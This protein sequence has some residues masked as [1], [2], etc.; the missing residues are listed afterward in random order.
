M[1][2]P[3][4]PVVFVLI[5]GL[6]DCAIDLSAYGAGHKPQTPL[7]AASTPAMDAISGAGLSGLMDPVEPGLACGSDTAHMSIFGYDPQRNYRGRGAFEAMGAGLDMA[8]GDVAFKCNFATLDPKTNVVTLR[9]VDR[10]FH[11]WGKGLCDF[12]NSLE[13][14]CGVPGVRVV[15]KHATEHRCG[16]VFKGEN[17]TDSITGTDPLKDGLPLL[18]SVPAGPHEHAA[19]SATCLNNAS[20]AIHKAL[21]GHPINVD[22]VARGLPPA[23]LIL[24]RGPGERI[25]VP[26][27]AEKHGLRA[28]MIAPTCIIAGLGKS[29][30]MDVVAVAGATGDYHTDLMAKADRAIELFASGAY[31]FGFVHVKAV[32]DAGHDRDVAT[33]V[34]LKFIEKADAMVRQLVQ[35]IAAR[36]DHA[37]IVVTGDH[38][39]PV[40]YGDHTFEPV[41]FTIGSVQAAAALLRGEPV[42]HDPR[43][44]DTVTAFGEGMATAGGLGRF[45]GD[46]V[47]EIVKEY[48][49]RN[50]CA[51]TNHGACVTTDGQNRTSARRQRTMSTKEPAALASLVTEGA[52]NLYSVSP[53]F[54]FSHDAECLAADAMGLVSYLRTHRHGELKANQGIAA[55]VRSQQ[56]VALFAITETVVG[57]P[58]RLGGFIYYSPDAPDMKTRTDVLL[59]QGNEE[60][61]G[62]ICAWMQHQYQCV[63]AL[64]AVSVNSIS[65]EAFAFSL[66]QIMLEANDAV[67]HAPLRLTLQ[68]E[69]TGKAVQSVTI[70][71][72]WKD[73]CLG[74]RAAI[75]HS[76]SSASTSDGHRR[77]TMVSSEPDRFIRSFITKHFVSLPVEMS[78]YRLFSV[79]S[80]DCILEYTGRLKFF[81]PESVPAVLDAILQLFV[82][83]H[84]V[85]P[86]GAET[87]F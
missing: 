41:P 86:E 9:R 12:V 74:H 20:L 61:L 4:G 23:N 65:M 38:T 53:L 43:I 18:T 6:A 19:F 17:L 24:L 83:Q 5:D 45:A 59:L 26:S 35:G 25:N 77:G 47:M 8:P 54:K 62:L 76:Q 40:L 71:I 69:S 85:C 56:D 82:A 52:W 15:C 21:S 51:M 64:H 46:Q 11:E 34:D 73:I 22:R 68:S 39:T 16:I 58:R 29:L 78:A 81:T 13:D 66:F 72:P 28:F 49:A 48:R 1:S 36:F 30:D 2:D 27:F 67:E 31:D 7:E 87:T 63:V 60:L 10:N 14:P 32:D 42:A 33:K 55:S 75:T 70:S 84:V 79:S 3:R 80:E 44:Q 57:A 50:I 37:T